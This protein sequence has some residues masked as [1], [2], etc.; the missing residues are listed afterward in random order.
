MYCELETKEVQEITPDNIVQQTSFWARVKYRQGLKPKA[1]ILTSDLTT[2]TTDGNGKTHDDMLVLIQSISRDHCFAYLP[3]GPKTEPHYE[4][5][6]IFLEELS[7]VLKPHLPVGCIFIRYD[8]PWENAWAQ[9][10]DF[11][12]EYG[13]WLGP[14]NTN[15]Q[16]LR[17]NFN[18]QKW[19][20]LKSPGDILPINTFF[21]NL[22]RKE[23]EILQSMKP[24]TRYN[25]HLSHR[26]GVQV[27]TYG[28][29]QLDEWYK[30][31]AETSQRNKV[32]LHKKD[33]FRNVLEDRK[34]IQKDMDISLLMADFE[35]EFLSAMFLVLSK[36]RGTYL[37]GASSS[38]KRN[39]MASYAIQWEA[40]KRARE[41]G[42][43]EYDMFG[44][45]PGPD[46]SH[47]MHGLYRFKSG[48]GGDLF[49]RMG[50]WDYPIDKEM[51][52]V[53]ALQESSH[54]SYHIRS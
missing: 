2:Q 27:R 22:Q 13:N 48:F 15:A 52:N 14:P 12:D 41:A 21:L 39:L 46:A 23:E 49:H 50:C 36:N 1:F 16:E 43:T 45:A 4:N 34:N 11:F 10:D 30:I 5:Y 6:G 38:Q 37:Y 24:K 42:C 28:N 8:L 26:K 40:I 53:I 20:L 33:F 54:N 29:E 9:E 18:T 44:C 25:I 35:G 32:T 7:E 51:Y 19:N 47:P 3:Y 17:I 31:Y